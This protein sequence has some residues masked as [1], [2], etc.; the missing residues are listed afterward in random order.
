MDNEKMAKFI[1][2]LRKARGLTQ[3][4]LAQ[5]LGITDKAVSKWERGL[6][7]PDITLLVPLAQILGVTTG[8]LLE[9]EK[10]KNKELSN[11]PDP[12]DTT[13]GGPKPEAQFRSE[14]SEQTIFEAKQKAVDEVLEYSQKS[15]HR[16]RRQIK[17]IVFMLVTL[18]CLIAIGVC[19]ICDFAINRKLWWSVIVIG[20]I[21]YG[22]AIL[23]PLFGAK[24]R[25]VFWS[26]IVTCIGIVPYLYL[27]YRLIG[28]RLIFTMGSVISMI[29]IAAIWGFY[30]LFKN[31]W[32]RRWM[33]F[34]LFFLAVIPVVVLINNVTI[35]SFLGYP[36]FYNTIETM[37]NTGTLLILAIICFLVEAR[38]KQCHTV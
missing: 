19:F 18:S 9:G 2:E 26:L 3:K 30:I 6:S 22:W 7:C 34:G 15:I 1:C 4:E 27:L 38:Q 33:A 14:I 5:R 12:P 20:S 23:I 13:D 37:V 11:A 25:H 31:L 16:N 28:E 35:N 17:G 29:S 8:E 32:H 24:R 10:I 21:V 36:M